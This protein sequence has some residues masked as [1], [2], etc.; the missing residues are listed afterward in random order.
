MVL[1]ATLIAGGA[2]AIGVAVTSQQHAPQ[3]SAAAAGSTGRS[4]PSRGTS[5][6]RPSTD[7]GTNVPSTGLPPTASSGP[8]LAASAP[9][10][11]SIPAI[12]VQSP[13]QDLG[14]NADGTLA[15]PQPGPFYNEAAWYDGSPTP[16]QRGPS[17]IEGHI[18][19]AADGPSV[20]FRLGALQPGDEIDVA[21]A[22]GTMAIFTVTGVRQYPKD[23]FPT[24]TV[25]GNANFA[26]LRLITC[27]GAFDSATGHYLANTVVF[28]ALTS[29]RP[30]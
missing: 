26:A 3:P 27:G 6:T 4:I 14:L 29:S 17:V 18:D 1:S 28:A 5:V 15:V 19:S 22:D 11:I 7:S 20:F 9:V 30:T 16:G 13:L 10:S 25:Y 24:S 12:S 8:I 2:S 21:R 23:E